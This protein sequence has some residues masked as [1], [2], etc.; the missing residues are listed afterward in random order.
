MAGKD[1]YNVLGVKRDAGEREIKQAFRKLA[2]KYHPDVNS[3]DK[4]AEAKFKEINEAYEVLSNKENRK[5]YDQYGDQ[6]QHAEQFEKARQ[7]QQ[8]PFWDFSQAGDGTRFFYSEGDMGGLFDE[9]FRGDG[10]DTGTRSRRAHP[11]RGQDLEAPV[12]VT[13]EEAYH[14][15]NRLVNL[16]GKRI[17]V[18]IPAGVKDSSRVR[19]AGKGGPGYA[20]GPN[21]DLFLIVSVKRHKTFERKGNDLHVEVPVPLTD[22]VL[23]GEIQVPTI[24]GKVMLKIPP[25]TQ[26][27]RIFRLK[28]QGMPQL[29]SS[30][31]GD[32]MAKVKVM[33]PTNLSQEEKELFEQL[34]QLRAG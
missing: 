7:Q 12:E 34:R 13:L 10:T 1:Y 8:T 32:L 16:E 18:K 15:T 5:K 19:I 22:A 28:G 17:E 33:L 20:R 24:K 14:G 6:W 23:G 2:R 27:G 3:G 29:S 30:N 9:F 31:R 11:I 21:G 26:N 25:E 4:S